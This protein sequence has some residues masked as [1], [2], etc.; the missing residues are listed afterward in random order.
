LHLLPCYCCTHQH[1]HQRELLAAHLQ[2][3]A[4]NYSVAAKE[5]ETPIRKQHCKTLHMEHSMLQ[6]NVDVCHPLLIAAVSCQSIAK[7]FMHRAANTTYEATAVDI[8]S[9]SQVPYLPLLQ[10]G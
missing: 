8:Q 5:S 9:V 4:T 10:A 2:Q 7:D 3:K 6:Y 1:D